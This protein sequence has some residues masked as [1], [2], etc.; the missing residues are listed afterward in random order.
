VLNARWTR[1]QEGARGG[2][3][4]SERECCSRCSQEPL[5]LS[6][7]PSL[8]PDSLGLKTTRAHPLSSPAPL[9]QAPTH[10]RAPRHA[11][12]PCQSPRE[13]RGP[14]S[15]ARGRE[16]KA[17]C[18][19]LSTRG[20]LFIAPSGL[21]RAPSSLHPLPARAP[22]RRA[23]RPTAVP[24]ARRPGPAAQRARS[25][26]ADRRRKEARSSLL[27]PAPPPLA[28]SLAR[29]RRRP[30]HAKRDEGP[31]FADCRAPPQGARGTSLA[32]YVRRIGQVAAGQ[33]RLLS[34][35]RRW[36]F[37]ALPLSSREERGHRAGSWKQRPSPPDL[38]IAHPSRLSPP[39]LTNHGLARG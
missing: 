12:L 24:G 8:S 37:F 21:S 36:S 31:P 20:S 23:Y 19:P 39:H 4:S 15:S 3:L 9:P 16:E 6:P 18:S 14:W 26:A 25:R 22:S 30:L 38:P 11:P 27:S 13:A 10:R 7:S 1:F 5:A 35:A 34:S 17:F 32:R 28:L 2:G 29:P 33:A